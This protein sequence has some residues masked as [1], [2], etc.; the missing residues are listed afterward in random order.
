[1]NSPASNAIASMM[2]MAGPGECDDQPLPTRLREESA[3]I[4]CF[5][6]WLLAGHFDVAAKQDQRKAEIG[7]APPKAE[8]PR[9][10]PEAERLDFDIEKSRRP[11]VPQFVDQDHDP[12]QDKQPPNVLKKYHNGLSLNQ[13][14]TRGFA[15]RN[16]TS[17][18]AGFTINL[19]HLANRLRLTARNPI[20]S[21][22]N[23]FRN[24]GESNFL[25]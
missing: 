20:Q 19:Q 13:T 9:T 8:Q 25:T 2:F 18:R 17:L 22:F 24:L 5:F 1:M 10:E 15:T 12:D 16:F 23:D 14:G 7:F 6:A 21:L 11:K 4:T 3:R